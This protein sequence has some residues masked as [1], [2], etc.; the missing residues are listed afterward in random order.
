MKNVRLEENVKILEEQI[1]QY[2]DNIVNLENQVIQQK[3]Q[4]SCVE[5]NIENINKSIQS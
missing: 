5:K 4:Y 1:G 2:K 3:V